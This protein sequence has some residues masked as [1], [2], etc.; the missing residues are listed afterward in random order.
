M[1]SLTVQEMRDYVRTFLDS[2][3]EELPDS[4]LD[5]W[6]DEGT[7]RIQ[8]TFEPWSF[9]QSTWTLTTSDHAA[10]LADDVESIDSVEGDTQLLKYLPHQTLV[11]MYAWSDGSGSRVTY[12]SIWGEVLYLWPTP[13][14]EE[15]F[16]ITGIRKP[17]AAVEATDTVDLPDEFHALVCEWMLARAYEQQD[18]D[19]MS[20]LK[21]GRYEQELDGFKRRY[22]R[23]PQAGVQA[24]G[25]VCSTDYLA[26]PWRLRYDFE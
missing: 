7:A 2:D 20:Q 14:A 24:V 1:A 17:T 6:R 12:W 19:I 5:I 22:L 11:E 10:T 25:E 4:L 23:S 8:R 9:Y 18:D 13:D 3:E 21:F 26:L 15:S 16:T